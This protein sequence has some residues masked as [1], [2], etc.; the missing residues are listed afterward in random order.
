MTFI[1]KYNIT[2]FGWILPRAN[3]NDH[4][5]SMLACER[6]TSTKTSSDFDLYGDIPYHEVAMTTKHLDLS[7]FG[8]TSNFF[9]HSTYNYSY[10]VTILNFLL[11]FSTMP[12]ICCC[13]PNYFS[14]VFL[15]DLHIVLCCHKVT[16]RCMR[17]P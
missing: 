16:S 10:K 9:I 6:K 7:L 8:V 4:Y 15:Y 2:L 11:Q 5:F 3:I 12:S 13:F 1:R 14:I 17:C